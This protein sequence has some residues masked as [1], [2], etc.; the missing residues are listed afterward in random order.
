MCIFFIHLHSLLC[1]QRDRMVNIFG[2]SRG[3][4]GPAGPPGPP[5][6][7]DGL[8][9]VVRWFPEMV[10]KE[11]RCTEF[12]CL[13]IDNPISDLVIE[14]KTLKIFGSFDVILGTLKLM[15]YSFHT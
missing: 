8:K 11:I 7:G 9:E 5:G 15:S 14:D 2:D 10:L 12:C 6:L 1:C 4:A 3:K 13:K